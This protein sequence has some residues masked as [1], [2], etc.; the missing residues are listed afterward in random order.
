MTAPAMPTVR[1]EVSLA[2]QNTSTCLAGRWLRGVRWR[3]MAEGP[4]ADEARPR[5]RLAER[6][7]SAC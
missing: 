4:E 3:E 2:S 6:L 7:L 1:A 5:E